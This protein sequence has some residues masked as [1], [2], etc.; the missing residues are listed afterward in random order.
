MHPL[1]I[2]SM[3]KA[4]EYQAHLQ[5]L[6]DQVAQAQGAAAK[7]DDVSDELGKLVASLEKAEAARHE[8]AK[9]E[10]EQLRRER[11]ALQEEKAKLARERRPGP[12][13]LF[14]VGRHRADP[15]NHLQGD[16]QYHWSA[17]SNNLGSTSQAGA[18][19]GVLP[20]LLSSGL[21][22][23]AR[24]KVTFEAPDHHGGD[25][26]PQDDEDMDDNLAQGLTT[27]DK[28]E[29]LTQALAKTFMNR[30]EARSSTKEHESAKLLDISPE[31]WLTFKDN[32]L[33]TAALNEWKPDRAKLKLKAAMRDEAAKAVQHIRFPPSWNLSQ[34]LA[35]YEEVFV[36]PAGVEL[37]QAELERA[38]KKGDETLL[39]FHTRLRYLFLRAYP[40]ENPET[41]KK[42]KDLF[43]TQLGSLAM[44]KELR[45]SPTYRHESYTVLLTRAQDVEAT[46]KT[47]QEAYKGNRGIHAL[48]LYDDSEEEDAP[49]I[50]ALAGANN[51]RNRGATGSG[52]PRCHAC[53]SEDH[54]VRQC[55][56][57]QKLLEAIKAHP[58][59]FGY[60]PAASTRKNQSS[61]RNS[62]KNASSG[63]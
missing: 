63:N 16:D 37:A 20:G 7:G 21:P 35:A 57:G 43:A 47:L 41:S 19:A 24:P 51:S 14:D 38:K 13:P 6:R 39:T 62:S 17:L 28:I 48:H 8:A 30:G 10:Q 12:L 58:Q 55:P 5:A 54:K 1:I 60:V 46:F 52:P 33:T 44:S 25:E 29:A 11:W 42:L 27:D 22:D 32:F 56:Y 34:A 18:T 9:K 2:S 23:W 31:S 49:S 4:K 40:L 26:E 36:H 61:R 45:T 53:D 59:R 3:D 15:L 50:H